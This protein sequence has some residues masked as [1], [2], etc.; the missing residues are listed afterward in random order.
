LITRFTIGMSIILVL[1]SGAMF[2]LFTNCLSDQPISKMMVF[3]TIFNLTRMIQF[4]Y[5]IAVMLTYRKVGNKVKKLFRSAF[6]SK[7]DATNVMINQKRLTN[8]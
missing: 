1:L 2:I 3:S 6:S 4:G 7:N 5:L 8:I